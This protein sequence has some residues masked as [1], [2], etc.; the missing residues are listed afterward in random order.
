MQPP[1]LPAAPQM[2]K[3]HHLA[4]ASSSNTISCHVP[5][6]NIGSHRSSSSIL[7]HPCHLHT[8]PRPSKPCTHR[9]CQISQHHHQIPGRPFP[10]PTSAHMSIQSTM[11]STQR[12]ACAAAKLQRLPPYAVARLQQTGHREENNVLQES[13]CTAP[14]I[15]ISQISVGGRW[16]RTSALQPTSWYVPTVQ[17]FLDLPCVAVVDFVRHIQLHPF[18]SANHWK[19]YI[20]N[21]T[22]L[23]LF[24]VNQDCGSSCCV[25]QYWQFHVSM[26]V[27]VQH[28]SKAVTLTSRR[29]YLSPMSGT[30]C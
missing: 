11:L 23:S 7:T 22:L 9:L 30:T 25:R 8:R 27:A 24:I 21:P 16:G 1:P 2:P 19:T 5:R 12:K 3:P 18:R 26:V 20:H 29:S 13:S 4:Y 10:V 17:L 28:C 14:P 6:Q 15:P